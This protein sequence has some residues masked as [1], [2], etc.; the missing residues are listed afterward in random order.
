MAAA[1]LVPAVV[2]GAGGCFGGGDN[3]PQ[4]NAPPAPAATAPAT[5]APPADPPASQPAPKPWP[6]L[7]GGVPALP[8]A[9]VNPADFGV[10]IDNPYFPLAPGTR[11]RYETRGGGGAREVVTVE[12]TRRTKPILGVSTV[13]VR[14]T[15]RSPDGTLVEDT[16]DWFA[17]DKAG[18]VWYFGEDTKEFSG[19]KVVT[20][21]GSWQAG[22]RGARAG[23]IMPAVP[24]VGDTFRQEYF[25]GEAEDMARVL[26]ISERV[27]VVY[28]SAA[29]VVK[30]GDWTPLEPA[31]LEHK[32][33]ARGVGCVLTETVK[34]G[35]QR[36]ELISVTRF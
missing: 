33:Y 32:Y 30:T 34:G 36:L 12:V 4:G 31:V 26:S 11:Y 18:N 9:A 7:R 24:R 20:T 21:A 6:T 14:D 23:V 16:Y 3:A 5:T 1:V 8:P 35:S 27:R 17:Q 10:P 2:A 22:V 29:G 25:K 19:G 15:V 13:V 28:G